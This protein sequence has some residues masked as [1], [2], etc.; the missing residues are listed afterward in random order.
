VLLNRERAVEL[1][2]RFG[3]E[4]LVATTPENVTYTTG[5]VGWS[6]EVYPYRQQVYVLLPRSASVEPAM[7]VPGQEDTYLAQQNP[8][9]T[10]LRLYAKRGGLIRE[11]GAA[12]ASAEEQRYLRIADAPPHRD[13]PEALVRLL[14]GRGFDRAR[15]GVDQD[16]MAPEGLEAL[17]TELP[18]AQFIRAASLF[19]LIR[20]VKTPEEIARLRH[21]AEVN[22]AGYRAIFAAARAGA[23]DTHLAAAYRRTVAEPGGKWHWLHLSAGRRAH[24]LFRPSGAPLRP[25][26][27]ISFDAGMTLDNYHA[28]TGGT[29]IV[30]EPT[31]EP[32]RVHRALAA[33]IEAA[34]AAVR[35]G[36]L[37]SAVFEAAMAGVRGNGLPAYQGIFCGHT[38]GVEAREFPPMLA[39]ARPISDPFLGQTTDVA[40]EAGMT[41]NLELPFGRFGW[42]GMQIE[43]SIVVTPTGWEPVLPQARPLEACPSVS[44]TL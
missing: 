3:L 25:G 28:D 35:P 44:S 14:R 9:I 20:M 10:D 15:I 17:R 39:P 31:E 11:A 36:A 29:G 38:I 40:L 22:E 26:D 42:G 21:A 13:A 16:R 33:G 6:Q 19:R 32:R 4:A 37:P 5:F 23:M 24:A 2:G 41:L 7:V 18:H 30:G 34:L 1:M 8:W 27:L 12:A 43:V